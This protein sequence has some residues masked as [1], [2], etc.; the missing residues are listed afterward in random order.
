VNIETTKFCNLRCRM[1]VQFNDGTTVSGPHMGIDE[2]R[3]IAESVFPYVDRWQPSVSGEPTLSKDF[4]AMLELARHFGV[5]AEVFTNGTLLSERMVELLAPNLGSVTISFDGATEATFEAIR[6]GAEYAAVRAN[7]E[8]LVSFCRATL[9]PRHQPVFGFNCTL[10]RKNVDEL[11]ALVRLASELDLDFVS[12]Y[13]VYPV[14]EEMK[15]QSLVH[16]RELAG[17][18][19]DEACAA[20]TELGIA[21]RVEALDQLTAAEAMQPGADRAWAEAD[22]VVRGLEAR[23]VQQARRRPWPGRDT[24]GDG[25]DAVATRRA[26]AYRDSGFPERAP[27]TE[28]APAPQPIWWCDFL[29]NKTYVAIGGDVRPC[30]VH[31]VPVLG[32]LLREPFEK[33]WNND[34]YRAMR[35][36]MV[37]K[38]PVPACRGCMH[39]REVRDPERIAQALGPTRVPLLEEAVPLTPALDPRNQRRH[40]QGPRPVLTWDP[41]PGAR[42]YAV[43]FSLD[44]FGS[45]LFSTDGPT[46]GPA[47]VESRYE[48]PPWAWRDAPVEHEIQWRAV[49]KLPGGDRIVATGAIPAEATQES[50]P[51]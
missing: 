27:R 29:W 42:A 38:E 43:H 14:T 45:V 41:V 37:M 15:A 26:R 6:E 2:F 11:P 48:V 13:H 18:R 40:R 49:A 3:R 46:G 19:I 24:E 8:R 34:S 31:Q 33:V 20:A 32:N 5:K 17:R 28:A 47:L 44:Q 36:R 10:M 25:H 4:A 21:F 16:H 23:E 35:Q 12:C 22:G 50:H 51:R 9:A 30:C 39:I 1:C 7:V